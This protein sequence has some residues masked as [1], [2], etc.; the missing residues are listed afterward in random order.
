MKKF[1]HFGKRV[2]IPIRYLH[3]APAFSALFFFLLGI[4]TYQFCT[5]S[6]Q[7]PQIVFVLSL[8]I[9]VI[10]ARKTTTP[11]YI[12]GILALPSQPMIL[13]DTSLLTNNPSEYHIEFSQT[14]FY[15][16]NG[17]TLQKVLLKE[18]NSS[19][20]VLCKSKHQILPGQKKTVVG[21]LKLN[22][23]DMSTTS[24]LLEV[25]SVIAI[26]QPS[27]LFQSINAAITRQAAEIQ[28]LL[29]ALYTGNRTQLS[30]NTKYLFKANGLSHLLALSGL[31]IGTL[32][33]TLALV[34]KPLLIAKRTKALIYTILPWLIILVTGTSSS[35]IRALLMSTIYFSAQLMR[36]PSSGFNSVGIA[37][38]LILISSPK[39]L[40]TPGF[41]LSFSAV[42][43]IIIAAK[44][45][46]SFTVNGFSRRI[47][48][49][50]IVPI[51][52]SLSTFPIIVY[53]FNDFRPL[54]IIPNILFTPLF[55]ILF[56]ISTILLPLNSIPFI[57]TG[58]DLIW[59]TYTWCLNLFTIHFPISSV[60]N[61]HNSLLIWIPIT[62]LLIVTSSK[63]YR[64]RVLISVGLIAVSTVVYSDIIS[65][66]TR[67]V[68]EDIELYN[69]ADLRAIPQSSSNDII[70]VSSSPEFAAEAIL[71]LQKN[72]NYH[73]IF[74]RAEGVHPKEQRELEMLGV[75]LLHEGDTI[76]VNSNTLFPR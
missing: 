11:F 34:L 48:L 47:V 5:Q 24:L 1:I 64:S 15:S 20:Q 75:G 43:G 45:A 39:T 63:V 73:S 27:P 49:F 52:A 70:L 4:I 61:T 38:L 74:L 14:P 28:P 16:N 66:H 54:S 26:S 40:F 31:H 10:F 7:I 22:D 37:G 44:A 68:L 6:I 9:A 32:I 65:K 8:I 25:D 53:F 46:S 2:F 55:S 72:R 67:P 21:T 3:K 69:R 60:S 30:K 18:G 12:C 36:R 42:T 29:R 50:F 23:N 33:I 56:T 58:V 59:L 76:A 19:I 51:A 41:Q 35:I 17:N 62:I 13:E 71:F 57:K